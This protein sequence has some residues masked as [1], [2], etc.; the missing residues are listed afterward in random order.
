[1][2]DFNWGQM[3]V[4]GCK[5]HYKTVLGAGAKAKTVTTCPAFLEKAGN[6]LPIL[7]VLCGVFLLDLIFYHKAH[8]IYSF[9]KATETSK[10]IFHYF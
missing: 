6:N 7:S 10:G 5:K 1:V 8:N 4:S 9:Y 2:Q 3:R